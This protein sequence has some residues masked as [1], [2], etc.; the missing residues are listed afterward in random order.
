MGLCLYS[1]KF[2]YRSYEAR[3]E[4]ARMLVNDIKNKKFNTSLPVEIK[5]SPTIG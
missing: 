3:K 1:C 4:A 2:Y 5:S